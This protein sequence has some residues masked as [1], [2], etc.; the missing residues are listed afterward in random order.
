[1]NTIT[2]PKGFAKGDLVIIPRTEYESLK[3]RVVPEYT[4]TP[5]ERRALARARREFREGK[6]IPLAQLKRELAGRNR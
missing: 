1:M 5:A 6:T 2:I 3:S 4:P